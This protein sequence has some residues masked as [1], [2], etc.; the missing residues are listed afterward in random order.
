MRVMLTSCGLETKKIEEAFL[1][2]LGK[3][4]EQANA[5]FI[6]TAAIDADAIG[7]YISC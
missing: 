4:P 6:P 7:K 2:F 3:A 1:A 5:L